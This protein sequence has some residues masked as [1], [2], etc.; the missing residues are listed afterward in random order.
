MDHFGVPLI[1]TRAVE[2]SECNYHRI[3]GHCKGSSSLWDRAEVN[4][5]IALNYSFSG[6]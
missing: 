1:R 3:Q 5:I 6:V 2:Y 4:L